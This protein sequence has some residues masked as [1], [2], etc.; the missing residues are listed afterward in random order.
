MRILTNGERF[1]FWSTALAS[2]AGIE[3]GDITSLGDI[4]EIKTVNG[5][6]TFDVATAITISG[7]ATTC[8]NYCLSEG[9]SACLLKIDLTSKAVESCTAS[10]DSG[11]YCLC[12]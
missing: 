10:A 4:K 11:D 6:K 5:L 7:S 9:Q 2:Q 12:K 3:A 8:Q 1:Q